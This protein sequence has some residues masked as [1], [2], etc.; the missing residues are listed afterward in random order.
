MCAV[1][2][3][4]LLLC[5]VFFELFVKAAELE[6]LNQKLRKQRWHHQQKVLNPAYV[7]VL[8]SCVVLLFWFVVLFR[9]CVRVV[10]VCLFI[11]RACVFFLFLVV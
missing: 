3:C 1:F 10:A 2:I 6:E 7:R 8:R 11:L 4:L 5:L 9:S